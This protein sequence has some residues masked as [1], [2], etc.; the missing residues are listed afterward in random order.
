[1]LSRAAA[2]FEFTDSAKVP[3]MFADRESIAIWAI[4]EVDFVSANSIM[5]GTGN[6]MFSPNGHYTR[7]QAIV[8]M[9][10]LY[11]TFPREFYPIK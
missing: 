7:E 3:I 8:T 5:G 2:V 10:R 9:L 1:M 4:R 11:R 6:N